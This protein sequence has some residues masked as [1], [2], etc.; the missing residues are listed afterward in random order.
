MSYMPDKRPQKPSLLRKQESRICPP[1][2]VRG[3]LCES[4]EPETYKS[5]FLFS[6]ET[7]DSRFRGN[8]ENGTKSYK[9]TKGSEGNSGISF[10]DPAIT[11]NFKSASSFTSANLE[12]FLFFYPSR[13]ALNDL[14]SFG[15]SPPNQ[16]G[17]WRITA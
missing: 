11:V 16:D 9:P 8:D 1:Y 15:P 17:S 3:R 14:H 5:G 2:Q 13:S 10:R 12:M 4:R 7:L 6:Q